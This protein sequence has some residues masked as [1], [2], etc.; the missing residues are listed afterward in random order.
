[1]IGNAAIANKIGDLLKKAYQLVL[2]E[3][4]KFATKKTFNSI[5]YEFEVL[6]TGI[7]VSIYAAESL[8]FIESGRRRG[9]KLPVQKTPNGFEL[10]FELQE[11]VDE[12]GYTGSHFYLAKLISERG[13]KGVPI[14]DLVLK[15][16]ADDLDELV[17]SLYA[18]ALKEFIQKE[19]QS[20]FKDV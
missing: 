9:A 15:K 13:I 17:L 4:K 14:T 19:I 20:I 2:L 18:G 5:E 16:I 12:V 6:T 11:W 1:M 10:V 7:K 8:V 3:N